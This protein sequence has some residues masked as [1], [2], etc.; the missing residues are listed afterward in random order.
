MLEHEL[1]EASPSSF[2][3]AIAF[4][5]MIVKDHGGKTFLGER[6]VATGRDFSLRL[7]RL[8]LTWCSYR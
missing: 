6:K 5:A 1:R 7:S 8:F 3:A 2:A 4:I